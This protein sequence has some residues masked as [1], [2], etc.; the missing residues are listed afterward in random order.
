MVFIDEFQIL[1][2][3]NNYLNSFLWLLRS[4]IQ[5]Q[6]NV[7]YILSGSM[8]IQDNLIYEIA[9]QGGAFGGRMLTITLN[10]F[11][12]TTVENYLKERAPNLLFTNE[13]FNRFYKCT[14]G[15][16][17]Y[18]NIFGRILPKNIELNENTVK[19]EFNNAIP[20]IATHLYYTWNRLSFREQNIIISLID[21]PLRR[22]DIAKYL[23][24]SSGS[25]SNNLIKLQNLGLIIFENNMYIINEPLLSKWLKLEYN[26]KGVY[27][28]RRI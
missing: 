16:P 27:P 23:N 21:K 18:V 12:K 10:P 24:V 1:K 15:I 8:S 9:G 3:L 11:N 19:N 13:G 20:N 5:N 28:Y 25:L 7:A 22:K 2:E 6:S 17:A 26:M 14:S 4:Y